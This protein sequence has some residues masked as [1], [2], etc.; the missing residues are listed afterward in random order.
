ML[1][2]GIDV[3]GVIIDYMTTV[4]AY[5]EMYDF[6]DLHKNGVRD[7]SELKVKQRYDWTPEELKYF[8]DKY[9]ISLTKATPFNPL[10]IEVIKKLK[11]EGYELIIISNRGIIHE[12]AITSVQEMFD[13]NDLKFD[14]YFWKT[15]D[16]LKIL[17][18]N[19]IDIIIDDSPEVCKQA[20]ENG[21]K[22]LYF[23][24]KNSIKLEESSSLFDIDNW[25]EIYR[26]IKGWTE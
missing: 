17:L 3:D 23:R 6:C 2:I 13:E 10:A 20:K 26:R 14:K 1:K 16:K 8:A 11:A 7:R 25:G 4:R 12:E 22:A 24:E 18:E 9:F 21:I 5:A 15:D 19:N